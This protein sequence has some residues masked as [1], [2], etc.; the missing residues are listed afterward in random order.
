MKIQL[1]YE[2]KGTGDIVANVYTKF[3]DASSNGTGEVKDS[4]STQD[5][6]IR[7]GQYLL[8]I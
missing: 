1:E 4:K 8:T 5:L 2:L 7:S 3:Y 6:L